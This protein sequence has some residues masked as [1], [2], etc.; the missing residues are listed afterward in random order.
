MIFPFNNLLYLFINKLNVS[1]HT[2]Y[3]RSLVPFPSKPFL[4]FLSEYR[5][6]SYRKVVSKAAASAIID[7]FCQSVLKL[8]SGVFSADE[9]ANGMN[10]LGDNTESRSLGANFEQL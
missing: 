9:V 7:P 4:K 3:D 1:T 10:N 8:E 6:Y 2:S 5:I